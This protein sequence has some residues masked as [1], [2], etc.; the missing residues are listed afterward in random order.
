VLFLPSCSRFA[1]SSASCALGPARWRR[2]RSF[3]LALSSF[4]RS[5][6]AAVRLSR[7]PGQHGGPSCRRPCPAVAFF[8]IPRDFA[9]LWPV[10]LPESRGRSACSLK[11]PS[12][13][14]RRFRIIPSFDIVAATRPAVQLESFSSAE[15]GGYRRSPE[16]GSKAAKSVAAY[17]SGPMATPL[18]SSAGIRS[19]RCRNTDL[20]GVRLP[21]LIRGIR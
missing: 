6:L 18:K 3:C 8:G 4:R 15:P 9:R 17:A 1:F 2:S 21:Q 12:D 20:F 14:T 7:T 13:P 10:S 11:G 5:L 19:L 16:A